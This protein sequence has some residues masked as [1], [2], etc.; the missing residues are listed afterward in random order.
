MRFY[1]IILGV[2]LSV[3]LVGC[4]K[5]NTALEKF[6]SSIEGQYLSQCVGSAGTI[7]WKIFTPTEQANKGVRV[8]EAKLQKN[9]KFFT[10][11]YLY[12][13]ETDISEINFVSN[14]GKPKNL[15]IGIRE[16]AV[17]CINCNSAKADVI[18]YHSQYM[19]GILNGL[20]GASVPGGSEGIQAL[21]IAKEACNRPDLT[22]EEILKSK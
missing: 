5:E 22:L 7:A 6:K 17:F 2:A 14:D 16:I 4:S 12:N 18:R 13:I 20:R 19:N 1:K 10:V 21:K 8:V 9:E 3:G 15:S 11:Q